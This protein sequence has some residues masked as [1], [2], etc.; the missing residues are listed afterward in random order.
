MHISYFCHTHIHT[1]LYRKL[2]L[3]VIHASVGK[4]IGEE[5][6]IIHVECF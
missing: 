3:R 2:I 5:Q 4:I 1:R 6:K